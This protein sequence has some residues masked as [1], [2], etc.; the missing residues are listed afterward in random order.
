MQR[1]G[2]LDTSADPDRLATATL[3]AIQGGLL[4]TQT[5]RDPTQLAIALDAA[6]DHLRSHRVRDRA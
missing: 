1:S 2:R 6:Y 3:A 5:N 4:L